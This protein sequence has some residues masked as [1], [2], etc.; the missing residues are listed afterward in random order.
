MGNSSNKETFDHGSILVSLD[1]PFYY[2]GE[3]VTG[4][5][6]IQ[7]TKEFMADSLNIEFKGV[8]KWK[9]EEKVET[10]SNDG[11]R[12]TNWETHYGGNDCIN[13]KYTAYKFDN[14]P[15]IPGQYRYKFNFHTPNYLPSTWYYSG[16]YADAY[17]RYNLKAIC[18]VRESYIY[19]SL[20]WN[21]QV[22][23]RQNSIYKNPDTVSTDDVT[24][25]TY[26]GIINNGTSSLTSQ[27]DST[28]CSQTG[29][30]KLRYRIKNSK[31]NIKVE[32]VKVKL[33]QHVT[34]TSSSNEAFKATH[35]IFERRYD[36]IDANKKLPW[37][38][39]YFINFDA[40]NWGTVSNSST[41]CGDKVD[42]LSENLQWTTNGISV[43][44]TYL[45]TVEA[46][47]QSWCPNNIK[48][49]HQVFIYP[50]EVSLAKV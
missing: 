16:I 47:H 15:I 13:L 48:T 3:E 9:W 29:S 36:G 31:W 14:S 26:L 24:V 27:I 42:I 2:S 41:L 37:T 7:L 10:S 28:T 17:I 46:V 44:I 30:C 22:I 11:K 40:I 39:Y 4:T 20:E 25:R 12:T 35:I 19:N 45:L 1:K 18:K 43:K 33:E 23:M 6:Y 38:P 50:E 5:V 32:Y 34:L 21:L 49:N 8:E